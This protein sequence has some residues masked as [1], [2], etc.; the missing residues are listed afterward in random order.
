MPAPKS[1]KQKRVLVFGGGGRGGPAKAVDDDKAEKSVGRDGGWQHWM[2]DDDTAEKSRA[3]A[4]GRWHH[5]RDDDWQ[6]GEAAKS[7]G[8]RREWHGE[9]WQDGEAEKSG[10]RRHGW[11]GGEWQG[12]RGDE[13]Q[14]GEAGKAEKS[15]GRRRGWHGED[16]GAHSQ[17]GSVA[18]MATPAAQECESFLNGCHLSG[19]AL[20]QAK[21]LVVE[22]VEE[23]KEKSRKVGAAKCLESESESEGEAASDERGARELDQ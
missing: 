21:E 19:A 11:H 9:E 18:V 10:G 23:M 12:G 8:Y 7:G 5:W 3:G 6:D 20:A 2:A 1:R 17:A 15:G 13:W 22:T 4:A 14:A 16:P